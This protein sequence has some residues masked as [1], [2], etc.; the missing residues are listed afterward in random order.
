MSRHIDQ[1]SLTLNALAAILVTTV[2]F[3]LFSFIPIRQILCNPQTRSAFFKRGLI[4]GQIFIGSLFFFTSLVLFQQLHFILT[5]DKGIRYENI[6]QLDMG[7][8]NAYEQD[9]RI[10]A[11]ELRNNPYVDAVCYTAVNSPIFTEQG[12]YYGTFIT[13][14]SFD[15][16]ETDPTREDNLM[17]V[18]KDF[19]SLFGLTLEAGEWLE[20]SNT[21]NFLVNGTGFRKL[22][23]KDLLERNIYIYDGKDYTSSNW[24][25]AG[26]LNDYLYAPMQYPV[27]PLFFRIYTDQDMK[28]HSPVQ[29]FYVRYLPGHKKEVAEHIRQVAKKLNTSGVTDTN[30]CTSLTDQVDKFNRPEKVIFSVFSIIAILCILIS[31]FGFYSLVSLSAQQ[32]KKEIAIRKVN[33]ATFP[34]ILQLFFREYLILVIISNLFALPLGYILMQQWLETYANHINLTAWPFIAVF[35]IT[36]VI[37][38]LSI[39]R[40]VRQAARTNPAESIKA[41]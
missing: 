23:Y 39:F 31:T 20:K 24:K 27:L 12:D 8:E 36:C 3:G 37:V 4:A 15:P 17:L 1:S 6:L 35:F 30:L 16:A 32:R 21:D 2:L 40:Q 7:F 10:L 14:L 38:L 41:E 34:H 22:G 33:G 29:Y 28:D 13:H 26:I 18:S 19:F 11:P 25:I 5:K 9:L